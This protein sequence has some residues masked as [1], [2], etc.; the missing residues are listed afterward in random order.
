V[1]DGG[2]V[3]TSPPDAG[4]PQTMRQTQTKWTWRTGQQN[5]I[6]QMPTQTQWTCTW[7]SI[8]QTNRQCGHG[9]GQSTNGFRS[10]R[11]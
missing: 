6:G 9:H 3:E 10:R 2:E 4:Q 7:D 8:R 1:R 11:A 5:W